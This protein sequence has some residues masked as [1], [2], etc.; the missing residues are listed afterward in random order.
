MH[1][2]RL[3]TVR[4]GVGWEVN[5]D[6]PER[7]GKK[8]P[9]VG[10]LDLRQG[11]D[12]KNKIPLRIKL[13][14]EQSK[15][16]TM[17]EEIPLALQTVGELVAGNPRLSR[18]FQRYNI[19]FCCD[20]G[21]TVMQACE[22]KKILTKRVV[23]DLV[24]AMEAG[25]T[26][27]P[28]LDLSIDPSELLRQIHEQ[29]D[30]HLG[31]ELMRIH[32]MAERVARVHGDHTPTLVAAY[33]EFTVLTDCIRDFQTFI[34]AQALPML[35]EGKIDDT[36]LDALEACHAGVL[37]V[38]SRLAALTEGFTPPPTACNTHRAL[39]TALEELQRMI[40]RHHEIVRELLRKAMQLVTEK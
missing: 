15:T 27:M 40:E 25:T 30:N 29:V 23:D 16:I 8:D 18:V 10:F 3:G 7:W 14:M 5:R 34:A 36:T 26:G 9:N 19:G 24:E 12:G 4:K 20:G 13:I 39:F 32:T 17:A 37:T 22:R 31:I 21:L 2:L 33:N 28:K 1:F 11:S 35:L 6:C 38:C